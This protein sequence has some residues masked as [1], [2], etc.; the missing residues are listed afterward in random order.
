MEKE[1]KIL[2]AGKNLDYC[3]IQS[4]EEK[5][6]QMAFPKISPDYS[7]YDYWENV[8]ESL[9]IKEQN[10]IAGNRLIPFGLIHSIEKTYGNEKNYDNLVS[11]TLNFFKQAEDYG[12]KY[13]APYVLIGD[14]SAENIGSIWSNAKFS[15]KAQL[16]IENPNIEPKEIKISHHYP[17]RRYDIRRNAYPLGHEP[18]KEEKL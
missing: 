10:P 5:I 15:G 1:A 2:I 13:S 12:Q 17:N 9:Q 16:M 11:Y 14:L 6:K 3:L 7:S 4:D 18:P 8:L